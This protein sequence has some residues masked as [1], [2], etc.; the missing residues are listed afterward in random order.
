VARS[1]NQHTGRKKA[2]IFDRKE[3]QKIYKNKK[4]QILQIISIHELTLDS[5]KYHN[6]RKR[7]KLDE[8]Q[9][10][11]VTL[12]VKE[13]SLKYQE[14]KTGNLCLKAQEDISI[15]SIMSTPINK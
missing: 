15:L 7:F 2:M 13:T 8:V 12:K 5:L 9:S 1:I 11:N 10:W 4:N 14:T 3:R 6:G